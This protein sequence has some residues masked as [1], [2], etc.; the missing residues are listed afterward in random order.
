VISEGYSTPIRIQWPI[1]FII[2]AD[3]LQPCP[4]LFADVVADELPV[5]VGVLTV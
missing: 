3:T 5:E 1:R 4:A 2:G